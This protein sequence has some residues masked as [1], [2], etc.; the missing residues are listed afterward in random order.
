MIFEFEDYTIDVYE[1][2]MK[3]LADKK[4]RCEC[5]IC[6]IFREHASTLPDNIKKRFYELGL[7][8]ES[9]DEVYD[10]GIDESGNIRYSGWWNIYGKIVKKSEKPYQFSDSFEVTFCD[11]SQY[12][13]KWF[14]DSSCIQMKFCIRGSHLK[15]LGKEYCAEADTNGICKNTFMYHIN[16]EVYSELNRFVGWELV[17]VDCDL[18]QSN[19]NQTKCRKANIYLKCP[20]ELNFHKLVLQAARDTDTCFDGIDRMVFAANISPVEEAE[21]NLYHGERVIPYSDTH[22]RKIKIF[23]STIAGERDRVIYDSHLLIELEDG[24]KMIFRIEPDGEEV[25]TVFSDVKDCDIEKYLRVSDI[26]FVHPTPIYNDRNEIIGLKSF[27]Q[28]ETKVRA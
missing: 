12:A 1:E 5:P 17:R 21:E 9:P 24:K 4:H 20:R 3:T 25:L 11:D 27:Y 7:D 26:W 10:A 13:P 16:N 28:T 14:R 18:I 6:S 23:E 15:K 8:V 2:K 19:G 22:I